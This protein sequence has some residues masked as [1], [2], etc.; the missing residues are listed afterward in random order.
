MSA[1]PHLKASR[2]RRRACLSIQAPSELS[3]YE[4]PRQL[5][6]SA[7]YPVF[8]LEQGF[9]PFVSSVL[10]EERNEASLNILQI[11]LLGMGFFMG[12][13]P[14]SLKKTVAA[15]LRKSPGSVGSRCIFEDTVVPCNPNGK[16]WANGLLLSNAKGNLKGCALWPTCFAAGAT[17]KLSLT[18]QR[19][20]ALVSFLVNQRSFNAMRQLAIEQ[21]SDL[22]V[23]QLLFSEWFA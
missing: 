1:M 4:W 9:S 12:N 8:N 16:R 3:Y 7:L 5:S 18:W 10:T 6:A 20:D 22:I 13:G 15:A 17:L 21:S 14:S 19:N 11:Q 2:L 23:H